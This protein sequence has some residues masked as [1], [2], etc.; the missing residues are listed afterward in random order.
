[1]G[2]RGEGGDSDRSVGKL[3]RLIHLA[4]SQGD[5]GE[6]S[7][8]LVG[9]GVEVAGALKGGPRLGAIACSEANDAGSQSGDRLIRVMSSSPVSSKMPSESVSRSLK[10]RSQEPLVSPATRFGAVLEKITL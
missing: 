7:M 4:L 8:G 5:E 10:K 2:E 1:M 3:G 6:V 9:V